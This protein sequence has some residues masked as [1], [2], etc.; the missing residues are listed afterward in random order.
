VNKEWEKGESGG[1]LGRKKGVTD[2]GEE[3]IKG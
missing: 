3:K 1:K 2:K